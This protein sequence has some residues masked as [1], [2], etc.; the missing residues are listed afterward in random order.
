MEST[1]TRRRI[2]DTA[3]EMFNRSGYAATSQAAIASA[4]GIRQGN[5]T[6][7]FPT[8]NDLAVSIRE[9]ARALLRA[10]AES[11]SS[12]D[13]CTDYVDHVT[14]SMALVWR[15]RFLLRDRAHFTEELPV[16]PPEAL[17]ADL[18]RLEG[19]LQRFQDEG[20]FREDPGLEIR[21]LARSVWIV[22]RYWLDH[23]DEFERV[24]EVT[25]EHQARGVAQHR[26]ILDP[27]LTANGRHCLDVAFARAGASSTATTQQSPR[28]LAIHS[29]G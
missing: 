21:T 26:A 12:G 27:C 6:Y 28:S 20:L 25:W 29:A 8:K 22:S 15:F 10:R 17:A 7:Y 23:L 1:H 5:L 18:Q 19:F 11:P 3:R 4:I 14:T 2:L 9:E 16:G 24:D 13:L